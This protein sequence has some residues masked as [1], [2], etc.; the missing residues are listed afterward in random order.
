M[1]VDAQRA[2]VRDG[3]EFR[4]LFISDHEVDELIGLPPLGNSAP[5]RDLAADFPA[6]G[7]LEGVRRACGLSNFDLACL[8]LTVAPHFDRRYGRLYAYLHDD[9]TRPQPS[10]GL[11]LDLFRVD[12]ADTPAARSRFSASAPL[13]AAGLVRLGGGEDVPLAARPLLAD[14]RVAAFLLGDDSLDEQVGQAGARVHEFSP[15]LVLSR[16]GM[17]GVAAAAAGFE[18][19]GATQAM[20]VIGEVGGGRRLAARYIAARAGF[21]LLT[22]PWASAAEH[23]VRAVREAVFQDAALCFSDADQLF[24]PDADQTRR[25]S[26]ALGAA[27]DSAEVPVF[28]TIAN[29]RRLPP[30]LGQ[31][32]VRVLRIPPAGAVERAHIWLQEAK[33]GGID[34]PSDQASLLATTYR[35]NGGRIAAAVDH[36]GLSGDLA[37]GPADLLDSARALSTTDLGR[38]GQEIVPRFGWDDIVL[39][40]EVGLALR[41]VVDRVR[42]HAVL[43]GDWGFD[44]RHAPS[45]SLS[46]LFCGPSGTGKTMAAEVIATELRL[47]LYRVDLSA[48]VSKYIGETEKNL[49]QIF[50]DAS[51]S[52]AILFF[53]EAD[54]LFGRRSEVR[55]SHDRY[56]NLEVSYLLQRMEDYDGIV[57]LAS[58]LRQ[59]MDEAFVRRLHV[60]VDFP[61]PETAARLEIWRRTIPLRTPLAGDVDLALLARRYRLSGGNIRNAVVTAAF[62]AASED[63]PVAMRHF[64]AA[65]RREHQKMGKLL[66]DRPDKPAALDEDVSG[67]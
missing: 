59:N 9:L 44:A 25:A 7:R 40:Q 63:S 41:E 61:F 5:G 19:G 58:N 47:P 67:C 62:L 36:A 64:Q 51:A 20:V 54:A 22:C 2:R 24:D 53:D 48:V 3:G 56:A 65:V 34:L 15:R 17:A 42:H 13:R 55:D 10:P 37:S 57:V 26:A 35:L 23:V 33:R 39:P 50:S 43:F 52:G 38:L 30:N 28:L 14:D 32:R 27:L 60:A 1:A 66:I 46:V 29:A 21:P 16:E 6:G 11:A 31:R 18:S 12:F 8:L 49:A 45:R 4:G